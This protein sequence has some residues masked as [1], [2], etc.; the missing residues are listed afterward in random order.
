[1][2]SFAERARGAV[3]G[4][5]AGDALGVPVE[6]MGRDEFEPVTAMRGGGSHLVAR[7]RT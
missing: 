5:L 1:M 7:P 4:A 2:I 6:G 3:L